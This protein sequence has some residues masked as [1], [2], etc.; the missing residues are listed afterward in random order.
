M[1]KEEKRY[2]PEYL[3]NYFADSSQFEDYYEYEKSI[4][5]RRK[6]E[7]SFICLKGFSSS[8]PIVNSATTRQ[9][10]YG[11][12]LYFRYKNHGVVIDPGIG[13]LSLMHH[14]GIFIDDVDVV[15]VTHNH[16]DHNC[17]VAALSALEYDYNRYRNQD[18]EFINK[19]LDGEFNDEHSITWYLDR[20]T[21]DATKSILSQAQVRDLEDSFVKSVILFDGVELRAIH[22]KH[23]RDNDYTYGIKLVFQDNDQKVV[24]GYTSDTAYFEDL[25]N[26][27][28]DTNVLIMNVSDVYVSDVEGTR[29]KK[30]H[31]GFEGCLNLIKNVKPQAA[32]VSEF[33]CTNGD[34]RFEITKALKDFSDIKSIYPADPGLKMSILGDK[35]SCSFCKKSSDISGIITIRPKKEFGNIYYI[36]G[37]CIL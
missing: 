23:I 29:R 16:I 5:L 18:R 2:V 35:M 4:K 32:L 26:F 31:L 8:T 6:I 15:I 30:S 14:N 33:C 37:N 24:W 25:D 27:Y 17:D 10:V 36:C 3:K 9:E 19:F 12:G 34:Y 20:G 28:K 7:D 1:G 13:F 11:G 21:L 22:T